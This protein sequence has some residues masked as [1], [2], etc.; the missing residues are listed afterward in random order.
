MVGHRQGRYRISA[1]VLL[2]SPRPAE[3][4]EAG[5]RGGGRGWG[6]HKHRR[7]RETPHPRPLPAA[8]RREGSERVFAHHGALQLALCRQERLCGHRRKNRRFR[9]LPWM[10]DH[11]EKWSRSDTRAGS[12]L[13]W[14]GAPLRSVS[15]ATADQVVAGGSSFATRLWKM[16]SKPGSW[17]SGWARIISMTFR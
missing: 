15:T 8:S 6:A 16:A 2:P 17:F 4:S 1:L 7:R 10:A 3:R 11:S 14:A 5:W 12:G 13:R 9:N